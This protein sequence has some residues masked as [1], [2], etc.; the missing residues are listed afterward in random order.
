MEIQISI[1]ISILL[2]FQSSRIISGQQPKVR[3]SSRTERLA[4][5]ELRSTLGLRSKDWPRKSDPCSGWS[6]IKCRND[7]RIV[8]IN[9][10]GLRRTRLGRLNPQFSVDSLGNFTHLTTFNASG[11]SLPGSIPNVFGETLNSLEILDLRYSSVIDPIP[12]LLGNLSNLNQLYLSGNGITG[13]IP[14]TLGQLSKLSVLDLSQNLITGSIPVSFSSL[15]NLTSLDLSSN[16]LAG[17]IPPSL[18]TLK[19]LQFL[20]LSNNSLS[21]S[22]PAQL[23]DLSSLVE[24]DLTT[25]SLSGSLPMDLK[26]LRNLKKMMVGDNILDGTLPGNLFTSLNKLQ[27]V[28]LNHNNL[29]GPLP[30][31]LWSMPE[32]RFV[33]VSYNNLTGILPSPRLSDTASA[34]VL[35]LSNNQFYGNLDSSFASISF[36]DLSGNYFE[37]KVADEALL[38]NSSLT[39]NCLQN[40]PSQKSLEDC[41]FFYTA[42]GLLFDNFGLP[43]ATQPPKASPSRKKSRKWIFILVG[44]LGGLCVIALLV[45]VLVLC[46]CKRERGVADQTTRSVTNTPPVGGTPGPS[47]GSKDFSEVGEVFT[48]EQLL[49]AT[50]NFSESNL[51]RHGHSGDLFRAVLE[52]GTIV[53]IKRVDIRTMKKE[54]Y[55]VELDLFGRVSHTRLVPFLGHSLGHDNEKLLVY[56]YMPNGDLSTSLY[57]KTR[58]DDESLQTL[59]WITRLKVAIGAA[60]GLSYLHHECNPPLVHR[61]V[62]ASSILLDDKFEVRLGSLSEICSQEGDTHQS[63]ITRLLRL[64]QSSEQGSSGS[65][66][67]ICAYDVYCFGKV[68]LELVT[69]KLGISSSNDATTNEWLEHTLPYISIY[70]KELVTKILDS[71]LMVDDD[72][73]EEVW[74][75]AIVA[76]SCLNPK[77]SKRP[78]MRYVLKALENPLKVVREENTGSARLRTTSSRGSWNASVFGSWRHSSSDITSAPGQTATREGAG[79]SLKHLSTIGSQGSGGGDL[80]TS[81]KK[82]S[83]DIFPEPSDLPDIERPRA[84]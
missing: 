4:L 21:A 7:G 76:K 78:L 36:I 68:L 37:G 40:L 27:F 41:T 53:V 25:N 30:D 6:G 67:A 56:R 71:S 43:N 75:M 23:G 12:S 50:G 31:V 24:L 22:I 3:L 9:I 13:I 35:N 77:P 70:E 73:L 66:A 33:D 51:I 81:N 64:P 72:L 28:V 83:S 65:S 62:Q 74:A 46:L 18:G 11:F 38:M 14:E 47:G 79:S 32:L 61:D 44:V 19:S 80:S 42:K 52:G 15:T 58:E 5:F 8:E 63:V 59:D 20:K 16:F 49:R 45:L 17:P 57:R 39:S 34:R 55:M 48:Y 10:S 82:P 60:E 54:S 2:L 1:I 29:S 26:G 84:D 69:G